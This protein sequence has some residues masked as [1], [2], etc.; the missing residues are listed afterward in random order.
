MRVDSDAHKFII[1]IDG[2]IYK[3]GQLMFQREQPMPETLDCVCSTTSQGGIY[4]SQ[5][6]C[7]LM[8]KYYNV[9][10]EADFSIKYSQGDYLHLED[11]HGFMAV[12]SK[13]PDINSALT[14]R[15]RCQILNIGAKYMEVRLVSV[16]GADRSEFSFSE[17]DFNAIMGPCQWNTPRF[18][19]LI[20]GDADSGVFS[21]ECNA[22]IQELAGTCPRENLAA[23]LTDVHSRC[24]AVLGNSKF[25]PCCTIKERS[26]LEQRLT[27]VAERTGY[28]MQAMQLV[29]SGKAEEHIRKVLDTLSASAYVYHPRKQFGIMQS[30]FTFDR[31]LMERLMPSILSTLRSQKPELWMRQPFQ[32]E[33]VMLL[34]LY[35]SFAYS[36]KDRLVSDLDMKETVINALAVELELGQNLQTEHYD[37][38]FNQAVLYRLVSLMNVSNPDRT[39]QKAFVSLFA[40]SPFEASLPFDGDDAFVI[41]NML[42]SQL[43][44]D[45]ME[46]VSPATFETDRAR[47][48]IDD[49]SIAVTPKD[50]NRDSLTM[51]LPGSL[52]LWHGLSVWI[53][54]K[55]PSDLRGKK[56]TTIEQY[57][58]MWDY[59]NTA[60]FSQK[61]PATS[62]VVKSLDV[63]DQV[64][65]IVTHRISDQLVFRCK[66][67]NDELS[68]TGTLDIINDCSPY[69]PGDIN[70]STFEHEG[71]PLVLDV[72]VKAIN[73]DGTYVFGMTDFVKDHM[74]RM[75]ESL[76]YNSVLTCI[77]NQHKP[78]AKCAPAISSDGLSVFISPSAGMT[79]DDMPKGV[80]VEV[81]NLLAGTNGTV[82]ADFLGYSD[83]RHISVAE[84]FHRFLLNYTDGETYSA[85]ADSTDVAVRSVDSSYVCELMNI[86]DAKAMLDDDNVRSYNYINYCRLIA[87]LLGDSE[88]TAFYTSRLRMLELLN[89]F[90]LFDSIAPERIKS[91]SAAD[92]TPFER[93]A[94]LR[95][96]FEQ[97]R[98]IGCLDTDEF[99]D[100]L[101]Q[102][103]LNNEAPQLQQLA[104]LVMAHNTVKKSGLLIQ[105]DDILEKIRALLK[106][107][108]LKS[109]KKNYGREDFH[110]EFK[111]SIIYPETS[112]R[113]DVKAQTLKIMQEICAF[114]NA[115][116]GRL[117]LGV[118]DIGYQMGIDEDLKH[119]LFKKSRDKY[120]LYVNDCVARYLGQEAAHYVRTHFDDTITG[121]VL[122]VDISP[123]PNPVQVEGCYYERMGTSAR[124][125]N[126]NYRGSFLEQRRQWALD[127]APQPK[128]HE[129]GTSPEQRHGS[130]ASPSV[131]TP[132]PAPATYAIQTSRTRGN[133]IH[134][135]DDPEHFRPFEALLCIMPNG[136][137]RILDDD[138]YSGTD[139]LQLAIHE[140]E[141]DGWLMLVYES[142]RVNRVSIAEL[143]KRDRRRAY[144]RFAD[145]RLVFASIAMSSDCLCFGITDSK[146]NHYV[147]FDDVLQFEL[148]NISAQGF[149]PTDVQFESVFYCEIVPQ[150]LVPIARNVTRKSQGCNLRSAEA[151]RFIDLIPGLRD[152][153]Q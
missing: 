113:I 80:V 138:D 134:E 51:P 153:I 64:R 16:L 71:R 68:G 56:F 48:T 119:P 140:E 129:S 72:Y 142:G 99:N 132:A 32:A 93:N 5:D 44:D 130:A 145:E 79:L 103:T 66:I 47:L 141:A 150:S 76:G 118:S 54:G 10:D 112:M 15:L 133:V 114:L 65:V 95:H 86:I 143:L 28:C 55:L 92:A 29:D 63:D 152:S 151:A 59:I 109:N 12:M 149:V 126:D 124:R 83:I 97:L 116:G 78:G 17:K 50:A 67:V 87:M 33:W 84:A 3:V 21:F 41:A 146:N 77:V 8:N 105:A 46:E 4:V 108:K 31:P 85:A 98:I 135:Y 91:L 18:R 102:S 117:Y 82:S 49:D 27:D 13:R 9:D 107:N 88:R 23:T 115:E 61:K 127:H 74:E 19:S 53:D 34:Q 24:L 120:E 43:Q 148:K 94:L 7:R 131:A 136:E 128:P 52:G 139:M 62:F 40:N 104:A 35:I 30:I 36:D 14:P 45:D 96:D 123:C 100:Y 147:R 75:R 110:T 90:A 137:Y 60:L 122:I 70:V 38:A 37:S 81:T 20:F 25:L 101:Y 73:P 42:C 58:K 22:F 39:L 89:D 69:Y 111:T 26:L 106:L 11:E 144:K 1:E 121:D 125:V 2:K 6:I 57:R